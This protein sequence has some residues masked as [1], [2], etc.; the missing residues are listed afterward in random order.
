MN[1]YLLLDLVFSDLYQWDLLADD[2]SRFKLYSRS[3]DPILMV[4]KASRWFNRFDITYI[5]DKSVKEPN[6]ERAKAYYEAMYE[7]PYTGTIPYNRGEER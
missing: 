4:E 3:N 6:Y 2:G 7:M 1:A 5:S